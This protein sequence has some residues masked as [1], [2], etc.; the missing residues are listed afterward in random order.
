MVARRNGVQVPPVQLPERNSPNWRTSRTFGVVCGRIFACIDSL[1][2]DPAESISRKNDAWNLRGER[3]SGRVSISRLFPTLTSGPTVIL[4]NPPYSHL[5]VRPDAGQLA[6]VY[7][8]IAVKQL[9]S[10]E[11]YLAFIEQMILLANE[12]TCS[13]GL[14]VPLSIACNVGAQ[15]S[16]TRDVISK[17]RGRWSFA[18]FDREPHALFGEDVKTR[19]AIVFWTRTARD[20]RATASVDPCESG[21]VT[22]APKCSEVSASRR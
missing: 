8:T 13:G 18:F 3:V 1:C 17:T 11:I 5:G 16:T 22:V 20:K 9:P 21:G 7:E 12:E 15:F 2:I 4:G 14:V 10:A 19:N 6:R